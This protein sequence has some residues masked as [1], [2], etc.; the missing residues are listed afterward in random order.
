MP[1]SNIERMNECP[2]CM[3]EKYFSHRGQNGTAGRFALVAWWD[4]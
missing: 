3:N 2:Q 4:L 1:R